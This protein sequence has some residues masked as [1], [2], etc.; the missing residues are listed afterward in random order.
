MSVLKFGLLRIVL[1]WRSFVAGPEPSDV[2]AVKPGRARIS[3][4]LAHPLEHAD[5]PGHDP[6]PDPP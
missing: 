4:T 3:R 1:V 5:A 6:S 2:E